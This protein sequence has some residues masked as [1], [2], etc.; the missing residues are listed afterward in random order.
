MN[1][2]YVFSATIVC[3][4]AAS[5]MSGINSQ[6]LL[7]FAIEPEGF[8]L[9]TSWVLEGGVSSVSECPCWVK[10]VGREWLWKWEMS[11]LM[12]GRQENA[13]HVNNH[14]SVRLVEELQL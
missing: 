14:V 5:A 12:W 11:V 6:S 10:M 3:P 7:P 1:A 8:H 4:F 13:L 9:R 2:S